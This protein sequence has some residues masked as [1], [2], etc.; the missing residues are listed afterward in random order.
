[1]AFTGFF[2]A[3]A[4]LKLA[5]LAALPTTGTT[6]AALIPAKNILRDTDEVFMDKI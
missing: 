3:G 2:L 4:G 1:L 6:A 5:K